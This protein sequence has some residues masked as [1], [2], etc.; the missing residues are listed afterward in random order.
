M[1]MV[2]VCHLPAKQIPGCADQ[3]KEYQ[4]VQIYSDAVL[5]KLLLHGHVTED[6][7]ESLTIKFSGCIAEN[8][9]SIP[10]DS[11]ASNNFIASK[12]VRQHKFVPDNEGVTE[13]LL[14][15]GKSVRAQG[16]VHA[17]L[18]LSCLHSSMPF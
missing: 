16:C 2:H 1:Q 8:Y 7:N 14:A 4:K 17:M 6:E 10:V 13:V 12:F 11:G 18:L 5:A 3:G 9:A 15:D